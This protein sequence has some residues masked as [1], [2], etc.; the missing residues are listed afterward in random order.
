M[1]APVPRTDKKIE[2]Q[3]FYH[4]VTLSDEAVAAVHAGL[5][6]LAKTHDVSGL[7]ILGR[8]G[9]NATCSGQS[10]GLNA[11]VKAAGSL[12]QPGFEFFNVKTSWVEPG[13][14]YP[15]ME[16]VVKVR[17]EIVTLQRPDLLPHEAGSETHLSPDEWHKQIQSPDAV[18]IDTRNT[19]ETA[20]G[21]FKNALKPDIEEFSEFPE[22]LDKT[23]QDPEKPTYIFCTG[24]IR[25][26]KAIRAMEEKGFKKVY[27]LDGGILNYIDQYPASKGETQWDGEC[28]VFDHRVA[29]DGDGR[30]SEKYGLCPHC[31]Q[32]S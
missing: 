1:V 13:E 18:I 24:G 26:E 3:T 32:P 19:Y 15:F 16:F 5:K 25:C 27:Q 7:I 6:D 22:W 30:A 14:K 4:F 29:V 12:L 2:V 20:I 31:G 10:E 28:F 9:L 8:E 23:G 21:T 11:F 17:K